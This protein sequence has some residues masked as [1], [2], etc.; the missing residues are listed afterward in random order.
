MIRKKERMKMSQKLGEIIITAFIVFMLGGMLA[1]SGKSSK[2]DVLVSDD[3]ESISIYDVEGY[4]EVDPL[5][6]D[7]NKLSK[8]N[9]KISV[10]ISDLANDGLDLLFDLLKKF[11]S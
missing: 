2:Q 1:G 10:F 11:V 4:A 3:F 6:D 5:E 8:V 7:E 9:E